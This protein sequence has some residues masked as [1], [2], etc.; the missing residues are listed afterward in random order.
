MHPTSNKTEK[1][2]AARVSEKSGKSSYRSRN[3]DLS[4]K[5][6]VYYVKKLNQES[7]YFEASSIIRVF[8]LTLHMK[9]KRI[10]EKK[11]KRKV[12]LTLP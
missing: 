11:R 4:T 7:K 6:K 2:K 12:I 8:N 5:D 3:T 9:H 1:V 10:W